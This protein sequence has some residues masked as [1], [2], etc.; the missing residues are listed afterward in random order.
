MKSKSLYALIRTVVVILC[1]GCIQV[2]SAAQNGIPVAVTLKSSQRIEGRI[3]AVNG[4][5]TMKVPPDSGASCYVIDNGLRRVYVG[6]NYLVNE[7]PVPLRFS[8]IQFPIWQ[9]GIDKKPAVGILNWEDRFNQYG[10]RVINVATKHGP[11]NVVQ[12][13]TKITPSYVELSSLKTD[14]PKTSYRMSIG[15]GAVPVDVLRKLLRNQ[16]SR[17]D[18]PV[19][20]FNIFDF[21]LQAQRFGEA[22]EELD[23]IERRFPERKEQVETNRQ[24]VRQDQARQIIREIRQ[25]ID[26]GQTHLARELGGENMNKDGVAPNQL[27]ELQDLLTGLDQADAKVVEVRTKVVEL[28]KRFQQNPPAAITA[29]QEAMLGKFLAELESELVSSNVTRLDSYLVQAADVTQKDQEKVALAIS[30]WLLG[31]NSA[32]PNFALAQ[33][34]FRMR[35][36]VKEYLLSGDPNRH[37]ELLE[38]L[39]SLE[40][41]NNAEFLA[42]MLAQMK[43]PMHETA[44]AGYT[45][46]APIEFSV[47]VPGTR[48]H[49][50]EQNFRVLVHLPVEYSPYKRYPL[51]LTLPDVGVP[52]EKQLDSFNTAYIKNVGRVGR[53]SRNGVIVAAVQWANPGQTTPGYSAREHATVLGAMRACF[54]RFQ[55]N[56]DRVFLHGRGKGGNLVY[57]VGLAHPEHFAGLITIG[58]VIEKFAKVHATNRDIPLSIYAVVGE[59]DRLAQSANL[60]TWNKWLLS[61]RYVNLLL[62]EYIGR[63]ANESFPDDVESMFAWMQYQQRRLPDPA[64][65]E[66]SVNSLRPWDNYYWFLELHGFPLRNVMWPKT[67]TD[68]A[69]NALDIQGE[70]KPESDVNHFILKPSKAGRGMTLWLSNEYVNFE[71]NVRISGRGKEFREGVTPSTR[72]MLEDARTRGDRLHPFWARLDCNSG[73]WQVVE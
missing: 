34:M 40:S 6:K 48:A 61:G 25:R 23:L 56:T 54:Q 28:V 18:S 33:S 67:W 21:F 16:I 27:L 9:D 8:E 30:G 59:G 43:P 38:E 49:P 44:T 26:N 20:Y 32:T 50:S 64:G 29:D 68:G 10:H 51:L 72:I 12:G 57:D 53:A 31:S 71:K 14:G 60:T 55:V 45:G 17:S 52:V 4:F 47:S 15:T 22:L 58:G 73:K 35:E 24:R 11:K 39:K 63:L 46:E 65:F 69:L 70:L 5:S 62:V 66:F 1:I 13:I 36:L 7:D 3:D 42:S 37:R 19:E 2:I 41:G